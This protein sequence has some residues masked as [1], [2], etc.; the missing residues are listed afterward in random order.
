[1]SKVTLFIGFNGNDR[2]TYMMIHAV[3][4][5]KSQ[6]INLLCALLIVCAIYYYQIRKVRTKIETLFEKVFEKTGETEIG[7]EAG[8]IKRC[9]RNTMIK[10]FETGD[11]HI[12]K[13]Y[14]RY[15]DVKEG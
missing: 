2:I 8:N 15:P 10:I 4:I 1:M 3:I 6:N 5:R 11:L 13:K 7:A 9:E 12:G 14:D